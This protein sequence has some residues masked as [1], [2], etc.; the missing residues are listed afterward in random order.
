MLA[1]VN[2]HHFEALSLFLTSKVV[3]KQWAGGHSASLAV[4]SQLTQRAPL[5]GHTTAARR[6]HHSSV[7]HKVLHVLRVIQ[8][9]RALR[10]VATP[11]KA[12]DES[13]SSADTPNAAAPS[14]SAPLTHQQLL[15]LGA[16]FTHAW[17]GGIA[18]GPA[19]VQEQLMQVR[20]CWSGS[21]RC[22][23]PVDASAWAGTHWCWL[24]L[25]CP[26]AGAWCHAQGGWSAAAGGCG[27]AQARTEPAAHFAGHSGGPRPQSCSSLLLKPR[28][29]FHALL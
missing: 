25:F 26:G 15:H 17:F 14:S 10:M 20:S 24:T 22:A 4:L 8:R 6:P 11:Y 21:S 5:T 7:A 3:Q 28:A 16:A 27:G 19:A 12:H 13:A 18:A 9:Q 29:R 23:A 2:S 1:L